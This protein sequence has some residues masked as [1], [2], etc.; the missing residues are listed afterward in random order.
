VRHGYEYSYPLTAE[1]TTAHP[2]ALP[3]THSFASVAPENV[4]L[5]AVKKAEDAK[6]LI[7]RVYEWAGKDSMVELHVPSGATGATVTNMMEA[8]EGSALAVAGDVVKAPIHPYEI[9]TVRVD[10]PNGGPKE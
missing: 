8:P 4:V 1:A 6:G 2:G 7:F 9:L 5:T 10:Y 3:A